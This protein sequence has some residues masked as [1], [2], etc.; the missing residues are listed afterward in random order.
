MQSSSPLAC[1]FTGLFMVLVLMFA[2]GLFEQLPQTVLAAMICASV[3]SLIK[4]D[5]AKM[6]WTTSKTDFYEFAA[7]FFAVLLM[8]IDNGIVAS[9]FV[10]LGILMYAVLPRMVSRQSS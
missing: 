3:K 6:M 1:A 10:S 9:V 2:A 5:T 7:A 4:L 8:G